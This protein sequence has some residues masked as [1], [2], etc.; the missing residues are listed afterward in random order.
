MKTFR[1][2]QEEIK[3]SPLFKWTQKPQSDSKPQQ[4]TA[5]GYGPGLYG[6]KTATGEILKRDSSL[7]AHK[8]L[9]LGTPVRLTINGKT[10]DTKVGDR[11]P[12]E[13]GRDVDISGGALAKMG[14]TPKE[15][16]VRKIGLQVLTPP[17]PSSIFN[18]PTK[19]SSIYNWKK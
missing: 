5:S 4:V 8:T 13:P 11:G 19:P 17:K 6:N 3:V 10:L 18:Y 7:I 9:K 12:F 2:F 14:L 1:E 15:L 16:G